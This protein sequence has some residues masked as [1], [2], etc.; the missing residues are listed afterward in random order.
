MLLGP[1]LTVICDNMN[2]KYE[3]RAPESATMISAMAGASIS[4]Q[5][6]SDLKDRAD[7][8]IAGGKLGVMT[9]PG[10]RR[11][12]VDHGRG[13]RLWDTDGRAY[14]DLHLGSGPLLLGHRPEPVIDAVRRQLEKGTTFH[15]LSAPAIDLAERLV[16]VVPCAESVRF[17]STGSEA[18]F[19][20][21]RLARA[22]TGRDKILKC[23]GAFHGNHDYALMSLTPRRPPAFPRPE[24]SS[25]GIPTGLEDDVLVVPYNDLEAV[26][27]VMEAHA[28]ELAAV[29][30]EP[31]QRAIAPRPGYLEGLRALTSRHG[32][33]LIFDEVVTGFRLA[34]GGAQ[35]F[36]GVTPDLAALGKA[37]G[38]GFPLAAVVGARSIMEYAAR[39]PDG[40]YVSGT[41]GGNP[42]SCAAGL[43]TIEML[44][45]PGVYEGLLRS[46]ERL[47][48]GWSEA[49]GEQGSAYG[50]GPIVQVHF[51]PA[52]PVDFRSAR[53][54]DPAK[55]RAFA[56]AMIDHAVLY[57]GKK[58]Y[59]SVAHTEQDLGTVVEVARDALHW[60]Q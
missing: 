50:V 24:R 35:E 46:G 21:L 49:L 26:R 4:T 5:T 23:E 8:F 33:V 2:P 20:A 15:T 60:I 19:F 56:A 43:A 6:T 48:L 3:C 58:A 30:V 41:L 31:V 59:L 34:L 25:L 45:A 28:G 29:I 40:A 7:R 22:V 53:E 37:L 14:I 1:D 36:Y 18:T 44:A 47:R 11:I 39:E 12:V 9:L 52:E 42:V 13:G 10:G 32:V 16:E 57:T 51:G 38:S 55:L 54:S 17:C 27:G